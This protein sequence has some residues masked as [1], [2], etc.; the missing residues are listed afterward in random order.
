M[1]RLYCRSAC[2]AVQSRPPFRG[3]V[4]ASANQIHLDNYS[5]CGSTQFMSGEEKVSLEEFKQVSADDVELS[6]EEHRERIERL[7]RELASGEADEPEL[8]VVHMTDEEMEA[9]SDEELQAHIDLHEK[10]VKLEELQKELNRRALNMGLLKLA[11]KAPRCSYLKSNGKPCRAPAMGNRLHCV[12]HTR[13]I[14]NQE[15]PRIRVEVLEN[16]ESLQLTVKQIMEQIV[17]G[18]IEPQQA[19][20]LLR[21]VQIANSTL[22][23]NRVHLARRKPAR[24]ETGNGWGNPEEN[25]G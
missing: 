6:L 10:Q 22:K 19:S 18:R 24:S 23:P 2:R 1:L 17:N 5:F 13:S 7:Q 9:L 12:F 8:E 11:N 15:N 21:A 14:D 20:L 25:S 16:R 4:L 3:A